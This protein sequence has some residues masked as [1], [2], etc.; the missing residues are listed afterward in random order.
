MT[1]PP[2]DDDSDNGVDDDANDDAERGAKLRAVKKADEYGTRHVRAGTTPHDSNDDSDDSA[3]KAAKPWATDK[4]KEEMRDCARRVG[5][6]IACKSAM[7][8]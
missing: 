1:P 7:G 8:T 2:H 5:A 6:A 3:D 4:A